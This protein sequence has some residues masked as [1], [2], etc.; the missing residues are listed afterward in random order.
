MIDKKRKNVKLRVM[1][2][3]LIFSIVLMLFPVAS[4]AIVVINGIDTL[5]SY[6]LQGVFMMLSIVVPAIFMWITK[7]KPYAGGI[8]PADILNL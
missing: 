1:L 6:W 7:I 2:S 8:A 3:S 5:R 4:G